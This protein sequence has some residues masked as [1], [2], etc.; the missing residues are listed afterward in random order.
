MAETMRESISVRR[1]GE[2][3]FEAQPFYE[4]AQMGNSQPI[5]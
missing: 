3:E 5:A 2:H 4:Q 1:T